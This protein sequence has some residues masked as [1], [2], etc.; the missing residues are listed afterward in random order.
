V[1]AMRFSGL[2]HFF[3][4]VSAAYEVLL[5]F[6]SDLMLLIT[7]TLG[8]ALRISSSSLS[9]ILEKVSNRSVFKEKLS[10]IL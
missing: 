6:G 10:H 4:Q 1:E 7:S 8:S 3:G 9:S 5:P 2:V